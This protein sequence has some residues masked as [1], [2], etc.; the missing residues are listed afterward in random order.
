M[1]PFLNKSST[2]LRNVRFHWKNYLKL[3]LSPKHKGYFQKVLDK[4]LNIFHFRRQTVFFAVLGAVFVIY[5]IFFTSHYASAEWTVEG[6]VKTALGAIFGL[7]FYLLGGILSII[8]EILVSVA[9]YNNIIGLEV[10]KNTW[11]TVRDIVNMFFIFAMLLIAFS[12]ILRVRQYEVKQLLPKL[13]LYAVLVNFSLTICGLFIDIAQV[14]TLTFVNAFGEN[15][16]ANFT[17][18]TDILSYSKVDFGEGGDAALKVLVGYILALTLLLVSI[19]TIGAMVLMFLVRIVYLWILSILSPFAFVLPVIPGGQKYASQWWDMFSKQVITAPL[20]AFFIWLSLTVL[21]G[22]GN[23]SNQILNQQQALK[24]SGEVDLQKTVMIGGSQIG[25]G[26]FLIGFI[27]SIAMLFI[28]LM[29]T[30]QM[31]G[32]AGKIAGGASNWMQRSGTGFITGRLGPTPMRWARERYGSWRGQRESIRKEK[33]G[34]FGQGASALQ[35]WAIN[36]NVG[37]AL[38]QIYKAPAGLAGRTAGKVAGGAWRWG[39]GSEKGLVGRGLKNV[40]EW[41]PGLKDRER[42]MER[43]EKYKGKTTAEDINT[44][45]TAARLDLENNPENLY[46]LFDDKKSNRLIKAAAATRLLEM[47]WLGREKGDKDEF[48]E[49]VI[50]EEIRQPAKIKPAKI[51]TVYDR[52]PMGEVMGSRKVVVEPEEVLEEEKVIQERETEKVRKNK[53]RISK[54]TEFLSRS[55]EAKQKFDDSLRKYDL[56]AAINS[57]VYRDENG[58]I[59]NKEV[60]SDV[61]QGK[62]DSS[63]FTKEIIKD[64]DLSTSSRKQGEFFNQLAQA[65]KDTKEMV[66]IF[67]SINKELRSEYMDNVDLE[68]RSGEMRVAFGEGTGHFKEV[69]YKQ[70]NGKYV[71]DAEGNKVLDQELADKFFSRRENRANFTK[72][73]GTSWTEEVLEFLHRN[74]LK[75]EMTGNEW[76]SVYTDPIARDTIK[77][78]AGKIVHRLNTKGKNGL[79]APEDILATYETNYELDNGYG[80]GMNRLRDTLVNAGKSERWGYKDEKTGKMKSGEIYEINKDLFEPSKENA[81]IAKVARDA[82]DEQIRQGRLRPERLEGFTEFITIPKGD[83]MVKQRNDRLLESLSNFSLSSLRELGKESQRRLEL[84]ID[85]WMDNYQHYKG[86]V[87]R[88]LA[89]NDLVHIVDYPREEGEPTRREI[90]TELM[91]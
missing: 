20:L 6:I 22:M 1:K 33:V 18:I 78:N 41:R 43:I 9:Q 11:G 67:G 14:F 52:G 64:L 87:D 23:I 21:G 16:V 8:L 2:F 10:V 4:L 59:Q 50:Q 81:R 77:T 61:M 25:T 71:R 34:R 89:N 47:R 62:V 51:E 55:Q 15:A 73:Y 82:L 30:S 48:E 66:R 31:G 72:G 83:K 37:H 39:G 60:L 49:R 86:R 35:D 70:E 32:A 46:K 3:Y 53:G 7:I 27:I 56:D 19:V 90:I 13:I 58:K 26:E 57:S 91:G 5:G 68:G 45:S 29:L 38:G 12:T 65:I 17:K 76:S 54:M 69:F 79:G 63:A 84:M 88:L 28:G 85:Y 24:I 44:Y 36:K 42:A 80:Y 75:Y 40:S 74:W